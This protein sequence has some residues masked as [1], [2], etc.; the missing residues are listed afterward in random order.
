MSSSILFVCTGNICRSP[1]AEGFARALAATAPGGIE[2]ASA[3]IVGWEGSPAAEESVRAAAEC[4]IDI[5]RHLARRLEPR[6]VEEAG[7]VI[8]M[9]AEHRDA[10]VRLVPA[11]AGKTFTLKELVRVL[12]ALPATRGP[13]FGER[14]V[15]ADELR[16]S[17]FRGNPDDE[18]VADPLGASMDAF[19][20]VAWELDEWCRRL[21]PGLIPTASEAEAS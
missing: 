16:R 9:A 15:R 1:I 13:T 7:V 18:D 8:C 10:V 11:A 4:G 6:H 5:S 21:S 19:R 20:A 12:E 2:V 14:V 17:G 3:G